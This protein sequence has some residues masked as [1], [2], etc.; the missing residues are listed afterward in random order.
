MK[1]QEISLLGYAML[2]ILKQQPLSGYDLRKTFA[3]TPLVAFSDS[4]G[5]IYPALERLQQLG[6]IRGRIHKGSGLRRSRVFNLTPAGRAQLQRWLAKPIIRDDVV[7]G[8]DALILRFSFMDEGLGRQHS[9]RFLAALE[10]ELAAYLP[11]L[12]QF[13]KAPQ[14]DM[15]LS[16]RLALQSGVEGYEALLRWARRARAAY[17]RQLKGDAS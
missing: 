14:Q 3:A 15:P 8:V 11:A 7:R 17:R 13:L 9:A 5:A 12:R 2:G 4:P 10:A 16:G 6:L 1:P